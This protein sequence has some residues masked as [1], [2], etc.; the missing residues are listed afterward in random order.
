MNGVNPKLAHI[1]WAH[2]GA[3]GHQKPETTELP[4]T[5]IAVTHQRF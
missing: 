3:S 5:V 4:S 1:L 2:L